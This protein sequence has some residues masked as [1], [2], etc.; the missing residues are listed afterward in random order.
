MKEKSENT[1][2]NKQNKFKSKN[3]KLNFIVTS[4]SNLYT[5]KNN[6][7]KYMLN[8]FKSKFFDLNVNNPNQ[9]NINKNNNNYI[10]NNEI[11]IQDNGIF[12]I[13][14]IS[15]HQKKGSEIELTY[16][17]KEEIIKT[18]KNFFLY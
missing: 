10:N 11:N 13:A 15:F 18:K 5:N 8:N 6:I 4:L 14:L 1:K 7:M 12:F 9:K 2:N 16:P 3:E 17:N